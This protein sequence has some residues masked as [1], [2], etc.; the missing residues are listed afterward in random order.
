MSIKSWK[1][2]ASLFVAFLAC[3]AAGPA[4][5]AGHVHITPPYSFT[6][7][8]GPDPRYGQT[9]LVPIGVESSFDPG[10]SFYDFWSTPTAGRIGGDGFGSLNVIAHYDAPLAAPPPIPQVAVVV[11]PGI[12]PGL[13]QG[14]LTLSGINDLTGEI[15]T[16]TAVYQ[17]FV[18]YFGGPSP[19]PEP[20]SALL[21]GLGMLGLAGRFARRRA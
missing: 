20:A 10:W 1:S 15:E 3:S 7:V 8:F 21:L 5:R 9:L 13:F 6:E 4:A 11:L 2:P 16:E 18:T 12:Y 17:V 14:T 19:T